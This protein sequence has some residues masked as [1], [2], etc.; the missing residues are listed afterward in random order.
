LSLTWL[1]TKA[2]QTFSGT[3]GT[4]PGAC[5]SPHRSYSGLFD[6]ISLRCWG[7]TNKT[8]K[9]LTISQLLGPPIGFSQYHGPTRALPI[10]FARRL[11]AM[12]CCFSSREGHSAR[13]GAIPSLREPVQ[14]RYVH[15]HI[16][17]YTVYIY[18]NI[19]T[20]SDKQPWF[21]RCKMMDLA[22]VLL[23]LN[24]EGG[25]QRVAVAR[26]DHETWR[27]VTH[28]IHTTQIEKCS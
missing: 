23:W 21:E 27:S 2:S 4:W 11:S 25:Q 3:F 26:N 18:I 9:T 12:A 22:W 20:V 17:I 5:T 14:L 1:C 19:Y 6:P 28:K 10:A 15:T 16:Y 24:Y 8:L 7:K 13:L